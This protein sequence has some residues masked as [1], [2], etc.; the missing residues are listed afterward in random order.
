M[1][2]DMDSEDAAIRAVLADGDPLARRTIRDALQRNG[3]VVVA[4]ATSGREAVELAGVLPARR[5]R[6]GRQAPRLDGVEATR[7]IHDRSPGTCIVL[8]ASTP[9]DSLGLRALRAGAAGYLSKDVEPDVLPR[10]LRGGDRGRG[11]DLA[12]ARD[13]ADRVLPARPARRQRL[14]AGALGAHRPRVGGARPPLGGRRHRGHRAHARALHG[15][16][17]L[18]PEEPLPQ[19]R[20][21]L[22]RGG[23]RGGPPPARGRP[24]SARRV[25]PPARF[26]GAMPGLH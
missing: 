18:A 20:R 17:A 24:L 21:P 10:V 23:G 13:V 25:R 11:R 12:P 14:P 19:A 5:G 16:R 22:A 6:D 3:I 7:V 2:F 15:D 9:D 1:H 26:P 8:L 4:E